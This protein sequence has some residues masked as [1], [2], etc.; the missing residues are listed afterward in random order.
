MSMRVIV[1]VGVIVMMF[2]GAVGVTGHAALDLFHDLPGQLA[3]GLR[4]R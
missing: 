3:E 1:V 2:V 4:G